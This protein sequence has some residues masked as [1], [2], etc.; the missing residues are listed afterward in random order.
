MDF[1]IEHRLE[2]PRG[3]ATRT[4]TLRARQLDSPV[5]VCAISGVGV[6]G[7]CIAL[8]IVGDLEPALPEIVEE[9]L[10]IWAS[11]VFPHDCPER[12]DDKRSETPSASRSRRE[13]LIEPD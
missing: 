13:D 5:G 12:L 4:R 6:A 2:T 10:K 11:G 9:T 3:E 8:V 1:S 7:L